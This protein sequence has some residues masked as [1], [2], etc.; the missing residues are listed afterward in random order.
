MPGREGR[1]GHSVRK[2]QQV[3]KA[4]VERQEL[5]FFNAGFFVQPVLEHYIP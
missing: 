4:G 5:L 3:C 1:E 2:E